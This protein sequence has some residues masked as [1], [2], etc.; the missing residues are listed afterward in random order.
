M[1]KG[2]Q[3]TTENSIRSKNVGGYLTVFNRKQLHGEVFGN[4]L[5]YF[6]LAGDCALST[7]FRAL[8]VAPFSDFLRIFIQFGSC[9]VIG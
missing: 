7:E 3:S 4:N 1:L 2:H 5:F 9:D 8:N 6:R